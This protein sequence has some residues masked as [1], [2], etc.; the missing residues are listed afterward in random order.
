METY[1]LCEY[2]MQSIF[3]RMTGFNEQ[4]LKCIL[5]ELA[6][7]DYEFRYKF[8]KSDYGECS[9][10]N[11]KE[12]VFKNLYNA[13]QKKNCDFTLVD[14][15]NNL[16]KGVHDAF[17]KRFEGSVFIKWLPKD[18]EDCKSVVSLFSDKQFLV[19]NKKSG[20]ASI[21]FFIRRDSLQGD[22][23]NNNLMDAFEHLY[24]HRN[25]CAHN[26]AS[27]QDNL[28]KLAIIGSEDD[29]YE[30]WFVRFFVM[31]VI[32]DIFVRLYQKYIENLE[33]S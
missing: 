2:V 22:D 11:E 9:S 23:K 13:I 4:K 8:L 17:F 27:Y 14:I 1:P 29:K 30:N 10:Y 32:D 24:K 20:S 6:T 7:N 3:L 31:T 16:I 21:S 18:Y 15:K 19:E 5:W 25:R 26:L 12:S 33:F 28:P